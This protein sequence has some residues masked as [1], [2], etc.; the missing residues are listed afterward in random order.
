MGSD[1]VIMCVDNMMLANFYNS[2]FRHEMNQKR[3]ANPDHNA[4]QEQ[5]EERDGIGRRSKDR[6]QQPS[7]VCIVVARREFLT[8]RRADISIITECP[9]LCVRGVLAPSR[10][11]RHRSASAWESTGCVFLTSG[12]ETNLSPRLEC[13]WQW[14]DGC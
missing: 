1:S 3:N 12:E 14:C 8:D 7:P 9:A 5:Q 11:E 2:E 13:L 4:F 6:K 10:V